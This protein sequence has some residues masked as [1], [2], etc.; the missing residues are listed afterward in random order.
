MKLPCKKLDQSRL[1]GIIADSHSR[2]EPF[3]SA[4]ETLLNRGAEIIVHLGDFL[5]SECLDNTEEI[6]SIIEYYD[7]CPVIGNNEVSVLK[8]IS[9]DESLSGDRLL[10]SCREFLMS[11]PIIRNHNGICFCHSLPHD[12]IRSLY[13]P[14]DTGTTDMAGLIFST[15]SY[16]IIFCGHSHKPVIFSLKNHER[17]VSRK[18]IGSND[19]IRLKNDNRY[20]IVA[21]ANYEGI[22][23]LLDLIDFT[24]EIIRIPGHHAGDLI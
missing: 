2:P 23:G 4:C 3:R 14:V 8:L 17:N 16:R 9:S 20:I 24:Y 12:N 22:C 1:I 19:V 21:G 11:L 13:E 10:S 6:I 5:D 18:S 15:T 7:V